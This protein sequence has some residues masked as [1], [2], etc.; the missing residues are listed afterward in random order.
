MAKRE[1][2][3]DGASLDADT[4]AAISYTEKMATEIIEQNQE[5]LS[6]I[7]ALRLRYQTYKVIADDSFVKSSLI[8]LGVAS[9]KARHSIIAKVVPRALATSIHSRIKHVVL[10]NRPSNLTQEG[11]EKGASA[12]QLITWTEEH[13]AAIVE[14]ARARQKSN[15]NIPLSC[16]GEIGTVLNERFGTML[17][18]RQ[19]YNRYRSQKLGSRF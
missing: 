19:W 2:V 6:V 10:G 16:W 14:E 8:D 13:D 7:L 15:G 5:L 4:V 9:P 12:T 18:A 1:Q 3:H 11:Q 17:T